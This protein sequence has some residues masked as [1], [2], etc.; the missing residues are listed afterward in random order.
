MPLGHDIQDGRHGGK[1][2]TI[3]FVYAEDVSAVTPDPNICNLITC[4]CVTRGIDGQSTFASHARNVGVVI[5][6]ISQGARAERMRMATAKILWRPEWWPL[7]RI[8]YYKYVPACICESQ[9]IPGHRDLFNSTFPLNGVPPKSHHPLENPNSLG[10]VVY[11]SL[12]ACR[13]YCSIIITHVVN[14]KNLKG[15]LAGTFEYI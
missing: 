8:R 7:R 9:N 2:G 5:E 1:M 15:T 10:F 6:G 3:E 14:S 13:F 11:C 12:T 4:L